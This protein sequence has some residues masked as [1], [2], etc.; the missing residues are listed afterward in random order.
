MVRALAR[1]SLAALCVLL[2]HCGAS[3]DD[4]HHEV[5][6]HGLFSEVRIYRPVGP[7][8]SL[9]LLLSGDGGW[10]PGLIP[11]VLRLNRQGA[12]VAGIDTRAWLA[13]MEQV[14]TTCAAPAASL[15]DLG[16]RLQERYALKGLKPVLIGH[17]A[18][19]TLA[20][21][22][23][24]QARPGT[25]GGALTL[26]FCRELELSKP[27]CAAPAVQGTR[28]G[29]AIRLVPAG[30]LPAPWVAM[31]GIED[32]VCPV[33]EGRA[34]VQSVPGARFIPVPGSG[35][36]WKEGDWEVFAAGAYEQLATAAAAS[37]P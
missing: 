2:C 17:S 11:L 8:R 30:V 31:H 37:A 19:A 27:L 3:G 35:H 5:L 29:R 26:S 36:T 15:A 21:V 34:F 32:R 28:R 10:D 23:L 33:A 14:S 16:R 22:A 4:V 12:L 25:F 24:A 1:M 20:Y 13:S 18:G 6:S 9:A 7:V